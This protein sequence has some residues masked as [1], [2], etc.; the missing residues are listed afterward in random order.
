[1]SKNT[2]GELDVDCE[3]IAYTFKRSYKIPESKEWSNI[4]EADYKGF[5]IDIDDHGCGLEYAKILL[6]Y[7]ILRKKPTQKVL[8][9]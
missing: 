1:M 5:H 4:I 7:D 3:K 9:N 2:N 8:G 6:R